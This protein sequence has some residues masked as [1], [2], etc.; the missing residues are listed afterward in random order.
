MRSLR[1]KREDI[2]QHNGGNDERMP[3]QGQTA[4]VVS[5]TKVLNRWG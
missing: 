3:D 4:E 5:G 2:T 1:E